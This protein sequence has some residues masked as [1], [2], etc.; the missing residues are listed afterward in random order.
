MSIWHTLHTVC[1]TQDAGRDVPKGCG[2]K[3]GCLQ[4]I[5]YS[6]LSAHSLHHSRCRQGCTKRVCH[7]SRVKMSEG[8]TVQE[9]CF[10]SGAILAVNLDM[11]LSGQQSCEQALNAPAL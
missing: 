9:G 1:T 7:E 5:T 11:Q 6:I 4:S 2:M 8:S 10:Q 3:A